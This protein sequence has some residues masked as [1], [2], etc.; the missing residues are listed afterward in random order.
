MV[1]A[2]N[3]DLF[4]SLLLQEKEKLQDRI[5]ALRK[6]GLEEKLT[7]ST[8]ELSAYD[9]HPGDLGDIT[10][11]REK[12][13]ALYDRASN[14][15][16]KVNKALQKIEDDR[17]GFCECCGNMISEKRL[18]VNPQAEFCMGCASKDSC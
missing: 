2:D 16:E 10:F 17:Y 18:T 14:L 4:Y 15:L 5:D 6:G 13:S 11:E 1:N 9:Q 7:E 3:N 8:G 12:D